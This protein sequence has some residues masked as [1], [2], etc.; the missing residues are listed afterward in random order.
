MKGYGNTVP[1]SNEARGVTIIII[2]VSFGLIPFTISE[3]TDM[4]FQL[5]ANH[6]TP[7]DIYRNTAYVLLCGDM[8]YD[9]VLNL[10]G[11]IFTNDF[12]LVELGVVILSP[13]LST[14]IQVCLFFH[15]LFACVEN[16]NPT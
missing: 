5:N 15:C 9:T 3:V 1:L 12:A 2:C 16:Q 14:R 10:L 13:R 4:I 11:V 7:I 8:D 6:Q